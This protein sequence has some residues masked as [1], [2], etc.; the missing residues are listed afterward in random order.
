MAIKKKIKLSILMPVYENEKIEELISEI[1][2]KI[3]QKFRKLGLGEAEVII[4]EDGS[5]DNTREILRSIQ[6]KYDL[7]LNLC[8]H[9]RGYIQAVKE[10]YMQAKGEYIFFTD[11]DGE[12]KPSDFWLLWDKIINNSLDLVV[13]YK[14]NRKPYYRVFVSRINNMLMGVLF[15]VWLRD[16]NCGFRIIKNEAVKKIIP[17][18]G[19]L[20]VAYNA[21]TFI[22]AKKMGYRYGQ[23]PVNHTYKKSVA[24]PIEKIPFKL[25]RAFFEI[26]SLKLRA[27]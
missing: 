5:R 16:S 26:F 25:C 3:I 8:E 9:R 2:N 24:L 19:S 14:I 7:D 1:N 23:V 27:I 22:Y 18:T 12:H 17:L 11:S 6:K 21:E 13:G 15:N 20:T 10:I 4:A